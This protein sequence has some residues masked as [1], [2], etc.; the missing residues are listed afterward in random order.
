MEPDAPGETSAGA[1]MVPENGAVPYAV[2]VPPV[3]EVLFAA[4][5]LSE[6]EN[7]PEIGVAHLLA[8]LDTRPSEPIT[9]QPVGPCSPVPHRDKNLSAKAE[10]AIEA[11]CARSGCDLEH[12]T[13]D[14]LRAALLT[15][16]RDR[17]A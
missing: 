1:W 2:D 12:L 5:F 11:A 13:K 8:A 17:G 3:V 15:A 14:S 10:A 6:R 16:L 7:A 4:L 9:V